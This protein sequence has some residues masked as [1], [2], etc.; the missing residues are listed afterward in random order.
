M[1]VFVSSSVE[2]YFSS[3]SIIKIMFII[4]LIVLFDY[5]T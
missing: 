5:K 3:W 4:I 2:Y 1:T